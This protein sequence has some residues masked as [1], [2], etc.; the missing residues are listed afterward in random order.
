[1]K[2]DLSFDFMKEL[3]DQSCY[4]LHD[5]INPFAIRNNLWLPDQ[6]NDIVGII[7][8]QEVIAFSGT[9]KPGI[10]PLKRANVHEDGVFFLAPGFYANCWHKGFHKGKYKALVQ[11]GTGKFK[12]WRDNDK[13][14]KYDVDSALY[15]NV[16]GLNYHTTRWDRQVKNVGDFSEGCMVQEVAKE[17]DQIMVERIWASEQSLFDFALFNP[18][19]VLFS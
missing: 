9:T 5:G 15:S 3:Y 14:G 6:F 8:G 7:Q 16:T 1:M 17:Y 19:Y 12:G 18:A 2:Y 10:S 11:F 13:D 4:P